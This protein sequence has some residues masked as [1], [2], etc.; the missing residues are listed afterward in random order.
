MQLDLN[1]NRNKVFKKIKTDIL[2]DYFVIKQLQIMTANSKIINGESYIYQCFTFRPEIQEHTFIGNEFIGMDP[3]L[4]TDYNNIMN[5]V[6]E[7]G[8]EGFLP[9][10]LAELKSIIGEDNLEYDGY[11]IGEEEF[12]HYFFIKASE[13]R[14]VLSRI[15]KW[16]EFNEFDDIM[17]WEVK[18]I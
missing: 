11:E 5:R 3:S 16:R 1:I 14:H 12:S 10:L 9:D 7:A 17:Y 13:Y 15:E 4:E 18:E 8:K 6:I 2:N